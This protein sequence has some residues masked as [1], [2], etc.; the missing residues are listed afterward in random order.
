[1]DEIYESAFSESYECKLY[2]YEI[3]VK[4][5]SIEIY[6]HLFGETYVNMDLL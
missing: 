6:K 4:Y 5:T 3:V 1:M 2:Y